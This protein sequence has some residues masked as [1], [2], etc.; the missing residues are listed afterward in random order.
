[1]GYLLEV[2]VFRDLAPAEMGNIEQLTQM[3]TCH[4]GQVVYLPDET[5]EVLYLIKQGRIQI[6]R[7]SPEGRKLVLMTL[8]KG[9]F[10][11]E[12]A[13]VGQGMYGT[14]AEAV[15]D[16]VLCRITPQ[17]LE[18]VLLAYPKVGV[19]F[20]RVLGRRLAETEDRLEELAFK[21]VPARLAGL[22][23]SLSDPASHQ[24]AGLTHQD[25]AEMV[26]TYRETA[27]QVLDAFK[28]QGLIAIERKKIAILDAPGLERIASARG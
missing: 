18:R 27:T 28:G 26:G 24:V 7:L 22:L 13:L 19:R 5:G 9:A 8:D 2:E 1:M 17:A 6:Y 16:C 10:F 4:R 23:L 25:L 20:L 11:G 15:D 21:S 12:M 14:Y 3:S